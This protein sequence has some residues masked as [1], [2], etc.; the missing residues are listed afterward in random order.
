M[1]SVTVF[2]HNLEPILWLTDPAICQTQTQGAFCNQR[3]QKGTLKGNNSVTMAFV[4]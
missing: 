2:Y 4:S 1:L 3:I